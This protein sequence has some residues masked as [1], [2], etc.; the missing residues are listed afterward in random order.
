MRK[1]VFIC[2]FNLLFMFGGITSAN[3]QKSMEIWRTLLDKKE[4]ADY[5]AG[6]FESMGFIIEE[7]GEQFTVFHK[8][9]HFTMEEGIDRDNVDYVVNLKL[10]NLNNMKSHGEDNVITEEESYRIMSVLFTP[11]T[12]APLMSPALSNPM[13]HKMSSME[14]HIQANLISPDK[15][16]TVS[17]TLIY[18]NDQWIV[19]PGLHGHAKRVF[20]LTQKDAIEYQK[21]MFKAMKTNTTKGWKE[22][23][24][25]YINWCKEVSVVQD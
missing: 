7:T 23:R 4:L 5:F 16:D 2:L 8:G 14:N 21:R 3:A 20:N 19:I 17:H 18:L 22:F 24:T 12:A 6:T 13:I 1:V 25:W 15:K 10:A 11:L 9:D